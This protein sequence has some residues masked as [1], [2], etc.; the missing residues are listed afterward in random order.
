LGVGVEISSEAV[1][2]RLLDVEQ[3]AVKLEIKRSE[4]AATAKR[5]GFP[6]PAGYYRGRFVWDE[7]VIESWRQVA[8]EQPLGAVG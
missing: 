7:A 6:R 2:S 4:A 1:V 8:L 5:E 3:V